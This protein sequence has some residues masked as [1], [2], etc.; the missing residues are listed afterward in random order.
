MNVLIVGSGGSEHALAWKLK[1]S[2]LVDRIYC[3]PGNVAIMELGERVCIN[4]LDIKGVTRFAKEKAMELCVACSGDV[5]SAGLADALRVEGL[6][7]FGPVKS[8][9][10]LEA[11]R[12]F[13][14]DFMR[15]H[16]IPG[17]DFRTFD[18]S[19]EA[20]SHIMSLNPFPP[21]LVIKTDGL[22][23]KRGIRVVSTRE[24]ALE[25]VYDFMD[26]GI[27]GRDG[28]R[29][30]VEEFAEGRLIAYMALCD[31]VSSLA[32]PPCRNYKGL[33]NDDGRAYTEGT[34]ACAPYDGLSREQERQ[35]RE[36][37]LDSTLE[38]LKAEGIPYNGVLYLDVALT[39]GGPRLLGYNI[40]FS[41]PD[42]Q[43]LLPLLKTDLGKLMLSA[44]SSRLNE[45]K[46][47]MEPGFSVC[48]VLASQGYPDSCQTG[49][50]I[51]GLETLSP[52]DAA[53]F[54]HCTDVSKGR[55]VTAGGKVFDIV[56]TGKTSMEARLRAYDTAGKIHYDGR[57]FREDIAA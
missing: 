57:V 40:H 35:I 50:T 16:S 12:F 44:A 49:K 38:G 10:A 41:D 47:E 37:I 15:R 13:A 21:R 18:D 23:C 34:G 55:W 30:V 52:A 20:K 36:L 33:Q 1:Q 19:A 54:H 25:T 32:L 51:T 22:A 56:G 4:P 48:V 6:K 29:I 17:P 39:G 9:A 31:G 2:P 7:V 43:T 14:K 26:R 3:V 28:R 53:V 11:S 8:G 45:V 42:I 27:F 5:L 24:R 46:I